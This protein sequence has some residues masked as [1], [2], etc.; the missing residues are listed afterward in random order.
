MNVKLYS[1]C[2]AGPPGTH[3][4]SRCAPGPW[5]VLPGPSSRQSHFTRSSYITS[6]PLGTQA[7]HPQASLTKATLPDS[8][9]PCHIGSWLWITWLSSACHRMTSLLPFSA[10]WYPPDALPTSLSCPKTEDLGVEVKTQQKW[11]VR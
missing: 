6:M 5:R 11:D 2:S 4:Y 9:P 7:F 1:T 10:N 8:L 3:V